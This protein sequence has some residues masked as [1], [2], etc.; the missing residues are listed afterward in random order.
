[1]KRVSEK[2]FLLLAVMM[3]GYLAC[4]VATA[5]LI[6]LWDFDYD[7]VAD[8][9]A[10]N[11]GILHGDPNF[12]SG[13]SGTGRALELT[14]GDYV[15]IASGWSF[16]IADVISVAVWI[17]VNSFTK[18]Y[19]TVIA[20]GYPWAIQRYAT[21]DNLAFVCH[22]LK[23]KKGGFWASVRG[24]ANVN[25]GQWHHIVGV[26]DGQKICLYVD[27]TL[28]QSLSASGPLLANS[29]PVWLG[30]NSQVPGRGFDGLMDDVVLFDH[31]L[32]A[33]DVG[34]LYSDGPA[35]FV[36]KTHV[37]EMVKDAEKTIATLDTTAAV[38]VLEKKITEYTEW[39]QKN[40]QSIPFRDEYL[41]PDIYCLL[42]TAKQRA[43]RPVG[44]VVAAYKQ[45]LSR[46]PYSTE[47]V[48]VAVSWLFD[49]VTAEEYGA[50]IKGLARNSRVLS[51][52]AYS[53]AKYFAAAG[54]WDAF[55]RFLDEFF[56]AMD[57]R[58]E[59]THSYAGAIT[60]A[61]TGNDAWAQRF[62]EYCRAKP[63]FITYLFPKEDK[64]ARDCLTQKE[65]RTAAAV[66]AEIAGKCSHVQDR[67][68][69]EFK[70]CQCLF[71]AQDFAAAITELDKFIDNYRSCNWL[72]VSN[73]IMLKGQ[74]SINM[75]DLEQATDILLDLLIEYP[76]TELATEA[77][78][79]IA[80]YYMLQG[81]FDD[82]M[83]AFTLLV[84][85]YPE[86]EY[87]QKSR[88]YIDR[89]KGMTQ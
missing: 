52:N 19:Q 37:D 69:Y 29:Y 35:R 53:I 34:K 56:S 12:V 32:D 79:F 66:Y 88:S 13:R 59:P 40:G 76:D 11:D 55:E 8:R 28:D 54:K 67:A 51:Y 63:G 65:Y 89:I 14:G 43:G 81:R 50:V 48:P 31:A 38:E 46:I 26:Y 61:L 60:A 24:D 39:R 4:D 7:S 42:A 74:S 23:T 25:D 3:L 18:N 70:Q 75:G 80:Y 21:T 78:F 1:M 87:A 10:D 45:S 64:R 77:N 82:A 27:G 2:C 30:G 68:A 57:L 44:E 72:Q 17:K 9:W 47:H 62:V 58:G 6:A 33:N 5:D 73:A 36:P 41:S 15:E 86:S 49:H 71:D 84:T 20:K 85:D 16:D 83:E 22:G